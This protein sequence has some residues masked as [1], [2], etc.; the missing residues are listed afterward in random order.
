MGVDRGPDV[1]VGSWVAAQA[2]QRPDH[3]ALVVAGSAE[4]VSYA[5]LDARVDRAAA[6]L[7]ALGIGPG[8]RV[9]A[10]LRSEPLFLELYFAAARLGAIFV[11]LNTRLAPPEL[12]FQ[13][14]D[15]RASAVIRCEDVNL[16]MTGAARVLGRGE[17]LALRPERAQPP[18][19]L[20]GGERP[21]VIL[22][23]SGTTGLPKGAVLP[24]RKTLYNTL[25]A[26]LY[27][28]LRPDDVVLAPVPLFHSFGLKILA[29]PALF[30]GATLVLIDRFDPRGLQAEV[31]RRRGTLVGAVPVMYRRMCEAGLERE[32]LASLR[33]AF[34][35]GAPLDLDTIRA[36]AAAGV[37]LV[38]GYGQTETSILCCLTPEHALARA[39]S[40]GRPVRHGEIRIGDAGGRPLPAGTRGEVLVR[41]PIV[42]L[43]YWER[44]EETRAARVGDWH[45]TGDLGVMDA[46]G[47]VTLVG[48][49][50]DMYISGGE[51]V[52]PAEVERVLEQFPQV[53]EVAVVGVSDPHWGEVGR[54][55][56][57]TAGAALD[58]AA[59]LGFARE[60][61]AAYKV[62][63]DVVQVAELPRT[64][65]GKVRKHALLADG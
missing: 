33:T 39:G 18:P 31:A 9:A 27:F 34:S 40:V 1:N 37:R 60:R 6:A 30:A 24:H 45:R 3:P 42:M 47:F 41:G 21:Q 32:Q 8:D 10:A 22:Y 23:T 17:F 20:P 50:K 55:Y 61:L 28:G 26:E 51:N 29:V 63:R 54:A 43:G 57:V 46:D 56:V 59:L 58:V 36:F 35:A 13:I 2:A 14:G 62:P 38:Q 4:R 19:P 53:A 15:C 5:E 65:S 64:P 48:R 7:G 52:Y 49:S 25:N 44:P 16:A 12:A 11:P